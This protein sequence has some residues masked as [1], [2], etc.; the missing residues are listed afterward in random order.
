ML[1]AESRT[2]TKSTGRGAAFPVPALPAAD[3]AP[4]FSAAT[5]F[6]PFIPSLRTPRVTVIVL[7]LVSSHVSLSSPPTSNSQHKL[8]HS[9]MA[10]AYPWLALDV[11]VRVGSHRSIASMCIKYGSECQ[12]SRACM[13]IRA[14]QRYR[15]VNH[16][17]LM[18]P[19]HGHEQLSRIVPIRI[20]TT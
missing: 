13:F 16:A 8:T 2:L 18:R 17:I 1:L 4:A 20:R 7:P 9:T 6:P 5:V 12:T 10:N 14:Q 15:H 3:R 11:D 19:D